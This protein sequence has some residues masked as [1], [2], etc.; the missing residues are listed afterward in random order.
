MRTK[1]ELEAA[2]AAAASANERAASS[3]AAAAQGASLAGRAASSRGQWQRVGRGLALLQPQT[4]ALEND[5][6]AMRTAVTH[7]RRI[8]DAFRST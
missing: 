7:T 3:D 1:V 6:L 2:A 8:E 5:R 4:A